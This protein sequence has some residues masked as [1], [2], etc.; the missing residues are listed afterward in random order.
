MNFA[1]QSPFFTPSGARRWE[2]IPDGTVTQEV[3]PNINYFVNPSSDMT[4][5]LPPASESTTGDV[6][7]IVDVGGV[8]TYNISLRMRARDGEYVQG[9]N[10][11]ANIPN[12]Q[13]Q[14]YNGGELVVQTPH[15]S[16]GLVYLGPNNSDG[17]PN[18]AS[19]TVQG[20]WLM[21]I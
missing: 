1:G 2:F 20:W 11:N 21:E 3:E 10:T 14:N 8:L 12:L 17:S 5:L 13:S 9:D 19:P 7:R 4:L 15:A 16:F 18:S 6:I